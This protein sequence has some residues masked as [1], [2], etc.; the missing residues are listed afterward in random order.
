LTL[1]KGTA[2]TRTGFQAGNDVRCKRRMKKPSQRSNAGEEGVAVK[3]VKRYRKRP[4][5][6]LVIDEVTGQCRVVRVPSAAAPR[7]DSRLSAAARQPV[8]PKASPEV[9]EISD[10]PYVRTERSKVGRCALPALASS[11]RW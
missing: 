5:E 4:S 7:R 11:K 1:A 10:S 6:Q 3:K 9:S 8:P 2:S